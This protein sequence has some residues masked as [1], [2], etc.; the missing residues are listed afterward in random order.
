MSVNRSVPVLHHHDLQDLWLSNP[1]G[2]RSL[3]YPIY[4]AFYR[5]YVKAFRS[6]FTD[7]DDVLAGFP[8]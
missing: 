5:R 1:V 8:I 7:A 4:G 2:I 3:L 6:I